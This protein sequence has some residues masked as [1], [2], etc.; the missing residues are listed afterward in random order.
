MGRYIRALEIPFY[1]FVIALACIERG[2]IGVSVF[3]LLISIGRL[4]VNIMTDEFIY[5]K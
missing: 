5:K 2:S 4:V 1:L 3:L